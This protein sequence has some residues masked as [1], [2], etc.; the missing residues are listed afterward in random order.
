VAN[1]NRILGPEEDLNRHPGEDPAVRSNSKR[2][3]LYHAGGFNV[4]SLR[5]TVPLPD[6]DIRRAAEGYAASHAVNVPDR[7]LYM[8]G[9][10]VTLHGRSWAITAVIRVSISSLPGS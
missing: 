3:D 10:E 5:N 6:Q 2:C 7:A 9:F 8:A 1:W 4:D